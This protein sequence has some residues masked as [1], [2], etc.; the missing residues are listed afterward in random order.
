MNL[1]NTL[2]L[3]RCYIGSET[4][5]LDTF[6]VQGVQNADT[7]TL[8][9]NSETPIGW[10]GDKNQ[11]IP[12]FSLALQLN[13][14]SNQDIE[15]S[16][17]ILFNSKPSWGI[18]VDKV[19]RVFEVTKES[20]FPL[21]NII[22]YSSVSK[23][24]AI[25]QLKDDLLLQLD[26]Q[27]LYPNAPAKVVS[28]DRLKSSWS[29]LIQDNK[30]NSEYNGQLLLFKINN[31]KIR[32]K[33]LVFGLS[34]TQV[35]QILKNSAVVS[36]PS[37]PDYLLGLINWQ[38]KPVPFIDLNIYLGF[39]DIQD[40]QDSRLLIVRSALAEGLAAIKIQSTVKS[41]TLPV[42]FNPV[43]NPFFDK[44][45]FAIKCFDLGEEILAILDIDS[46]IAIKTEFS[47]I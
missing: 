4:Y 15:K 8:N 34:V 45:S 7:L 44:K 25:V 22:K 6:W 13:L 14:S 28:E 41:L 20:V 27:Y 36:V 42:N 35:L 11:K 31:E 39:T 19:S 17:V 38:G 1:T 33:N 43:D 40:S 9:K 2:Q 32:G 37:A 30:A 5:C 46:I 26:P 10:L 21:P 29:S 23:F 18:I 47:L 12:I 3:I 24:Q 16:K